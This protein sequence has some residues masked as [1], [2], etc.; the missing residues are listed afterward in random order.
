[1]D[2]MTES[3][4]RCH[5]LS[6]AIALI[7][8]SSSSSNVRGKSR[9]KEHARFARPSPPDFARHEDPRSRP[10]ISWFSSNREI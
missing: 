4:Y 2:I 8:G 3:K 5:S 1:M 6:D 7:L 9:E 10:P